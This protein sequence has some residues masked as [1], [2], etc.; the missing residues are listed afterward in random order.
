M[1]ELNMRKQLTLAFGTDHPAGKWSQRHLSPAVV[2]AMEDGHVTRLDTAE[3][4]ALESKSQAEARNATVRV[5]PAELDEEAQ[6]EKSMSV[7][8]RV[9]FRRIPNFNDKK[10]FVEAKSMWRSMRS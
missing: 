2:L 10:Q 8:L 3:R 1:C 6:A 5:Q 9:D 7:C 4:F